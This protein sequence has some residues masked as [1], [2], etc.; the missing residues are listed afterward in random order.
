MPSVRDFTVKDG[1]SGAQ[2]DFEP[3]IDHLAQDLTHLLA[4]HVVHSVSPGNVFKA[5]NGTTWTVTIDEDDHDDHH[6][7]GYDDVMHVEDVKE[8]SAAAGIIVY[9]PKARR[10]TTVATTTTGTPLRILMPV[11]G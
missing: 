4:S 3:A 8:S 9:D 1:S 10:K 6:F 5:G 2:A 7:L 11:N